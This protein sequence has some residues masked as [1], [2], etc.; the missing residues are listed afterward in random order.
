MRKKWS[1]LAFGFLVAA[2]AHI[3]IKEKRSVK[4]YMLEQGIRLSRA[5]R[6]FMYKEEAMKAL[7]KMAPQT[8]GEYEGTNYQ[9]KMP[10]TVDKHYGSTVYTVNDKQDK[11]QRVVLY[12]HGGAWFQDPLKIHF[13]FIDELA[14][15]LNAKVIMPVYPKIPHQDYQATY[16]LFEKLYHDLLNQVADSKQIVVMGDSA[17][18][19]IALSFAQLLKE[20]HIVQPGHIVLISP[21]LDATMQHPEIPDYL[22]KDPMVGVDGS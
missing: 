14:E 10:V 8:A 4:S 1:T 17:G 15:T 21:V 18:G 11:H 5:K 16:V 20:K 19:Q 2:Y 12:A 3:R 22:K 13:E 9:F 7:E 6:R